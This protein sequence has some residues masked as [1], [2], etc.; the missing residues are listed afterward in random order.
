[1]RLSWH[2]CY[3]GR[4][5]IPVAAT[6]RAREGV[7]SVCYAWAISAVDPLSL[8]SGVLSDSFLPTYQQRIEH[9]TPTFSIN[10][11]EVSLACN[12]FP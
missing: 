11:M 8:I 5:H 9:S 6:L 3:Y 12:I 7:S 10:D 4:Y 1:M 2:C